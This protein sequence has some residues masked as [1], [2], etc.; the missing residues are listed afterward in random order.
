MNI[1]YNEGVWRMYLSILDPQSDEILGEA[2]YSKKRNTF[3][4][5][6]ATRRN[7][8]GALIYT[9]WEITPQSIAEDRWSKLLTDDANIAKCY[10]TIC[11]QMDYDFSDLDNA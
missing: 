2:S 1:T 6:Y 4:Y 10:E 8:A 5:R 3:A 7:N 11:D 9:D